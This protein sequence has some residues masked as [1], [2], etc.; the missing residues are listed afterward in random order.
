M[1]GPN[2]MLREAEYLDCGFL[3]AQSQET[4]S[5][6]LGDQSL[7]DKDKRTLEDASEFL[8]KIADGAELVSTGRSNFHNS[9]T[10][11]QALDFAMG[12]LEILSGSINDGKVADFFRELAAAMVQASQG[13]AADHDKLEMTKEF[14]EILYGSAIETLNSD[15]PKLGDRSSKLCF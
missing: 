12:P 8:N 3:A 7:S 14:F 1:S 11:M 5:K 2:V 10:S 15:F 9:R 6:I 13:S 4:I